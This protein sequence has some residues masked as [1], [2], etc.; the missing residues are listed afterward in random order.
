[1]TESARCSVWR[2]K[3]FTLLELMVAIVISGM[4]ALLAYGAITAGL[5]TRDRIDA[6]R[7]NAQSRALARP[8]IV[9][10]LR[11]IADASSATQSVFQL[12]QTSAGGLALVV[13]FTRGV[14]NPMGAS[15]L[16]KMTLAT[17]ER[18]LRIDA[19]PLEDA[20]QSPISTIIPGVHD[21]R[22]R[23]LPTRQ[24]QMWVT[25]WESPRQHP[26]AIKIE[27]LDSL[28]QMIE[29]PLVITTSFEGGA[30]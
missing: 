9:D 14:E 25:N 2:Q 27:M 23:V 22:L 12:Q 3:G 29:A 13:F 24:D 6:Y 26:Y 21:V 10:A 15:G 20:T 4:I 19:V 8:L 5:S 1:M 7:R 16:W 30:R 11:H 28:A 18:G 17:S